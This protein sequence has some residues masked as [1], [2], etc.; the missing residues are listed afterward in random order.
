MSN[1]KHSSMFVNEMTIVD[2]AYIDDKGYVV[3]GSFNP[4]FLVSGE[5][6]EHEQVVIDFSKVK[7]QLKSIV[8]DNVNGF[9]H[10]LLIIQGWSLA[11]IEVDWNTAE[12]Q[13]RVTIRTPEA[14]LCMPENAVRIVETNG[15]PYNT[16][17]IGA[18]LGSYVDA[19]MKKIHGNHISV[20]CVNTT[21]SHYLSPFDHTV[22]GNY[23]TTTFRYSHGLKYSTSWGCKNVAHGHLSFVQLFADPSLT[24]FD[25]EYV[26]FAVGDLEIDIATDLDGTVFI[27]D[28]N[29]IHD[30]DGFIDIEYT[31]ERG[32]FYA[33][34]SKNHKIVVLPTESTVENLVDYVEAT[35]HERLTALGVTHLFIS[36]GL[37]KGAFV[38]P[39]KGANN[40]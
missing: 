20:T 10:K 14:I 26:E 35:Y 15:L 34:Y 9:D 17:N 27:F 21:T 11:S 37:S 4:S 18:A 23:G 31:T 13:N 39:T 19:E 30:R 22:T 1:T 36:E 2:H 33:W 40:G 6:D 28:E 32:K 25:P 24:E 5:V 8:D 16:E 3:G 38:C 29:I 12:Q 7:K